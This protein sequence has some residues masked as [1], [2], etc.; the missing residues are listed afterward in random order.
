M[1]HGD[2]TTVSNTAVVGA[3]PTPHIITGQLSSSNQQAVS[4]GWR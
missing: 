3:R 1:A 4:N 2:Q